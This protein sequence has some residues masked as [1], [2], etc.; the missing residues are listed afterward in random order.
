MTSSK[1]ILSGEG[2]V[3]F[4]SVMSFFDNEKF[5]VFF[6]YTDRGIPQYGKWMMID[7]GEWPTLD[8]LKAYNVS[9]KILEDIAFNNKARTIYVHKNTSVV[10]YTHTGFVDFTEKLIGQKT[11]HN[12]K[13]SSAIVF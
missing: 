12:I 10:L 2:I 3:D 7:V 4:H 8:N 1:I 5:V 11:V 6:E 13:I 9:K